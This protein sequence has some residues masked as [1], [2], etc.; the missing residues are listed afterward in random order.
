MLEF[1]RSIGFS[2]SKYRM[3]VR[4]KGND[5]LRDLAESVTMGN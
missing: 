3:M 5:W 2:G 4:A 1:V